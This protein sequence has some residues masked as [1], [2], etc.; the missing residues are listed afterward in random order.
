MATDLK[1]L[2]GNLDLAQLN[3]SSLKTDDTKAALEAAKSAYE[4]ALVAA[5][6]DDS[7]GIASNKAAP[8]GAKGTV[9]TPKASIAKAGDGDAA[10]TDES[11]KKSEINAQT[12]DE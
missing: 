9:P 11:E 3:H 6:T 2:K 7:D 5:D 10:D 4:A 8:K 12:E 1:R